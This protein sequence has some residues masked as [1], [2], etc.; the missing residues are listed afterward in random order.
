MCIKYKYFARFTY[1]VGNNYNN[2]F[3]LRYVKPIKLNT[4][5]YK[6]SV[7]FFENKPTYLLV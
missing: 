1:Y 7:Y 3:R 5:I 4:I 2:T 6:T